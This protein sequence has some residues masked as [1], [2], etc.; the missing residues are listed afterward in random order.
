MRRR[1]LAKSRTVQLFGAG[2]L[3][4]QTPSEIRNVTT[5]FKAGVGYDSRSLIA[6][7]KGRIGID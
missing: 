6:A 5:V 7:V 3:T 4:A 2:R 1:A